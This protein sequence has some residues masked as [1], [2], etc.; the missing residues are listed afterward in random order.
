MADVIAT[1]EQSEAV[2]LFDALGW[3]YKEIATKQG[4]PLGTIMSRIYRGRAKLQ[5]RLVGWR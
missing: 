1:P 2:W 4:V 3:T 5:E